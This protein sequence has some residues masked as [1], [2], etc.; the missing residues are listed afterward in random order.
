MMVIKKFFTS[1]CAPCAELDSA[2]AQALVYYPD[3]IVEHIDVDDHPALAR[4]FNVR[5]VPT[6]IKFRDG[7]EIHRAIGALNMENIKHWLK[8]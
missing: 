7:I 8:S 3:I 6:M 5:S 2:L 1:W 4:Q